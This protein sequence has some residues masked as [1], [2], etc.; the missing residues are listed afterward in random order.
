M[1][2]PGNVILARVFLAFFGLISAWI[3]GLEVHRLMTWPTV[4]ATIIGTGVQGVHGGRNGIGYR[5][6]AAYSYAVNGSLDTAT[7]VTV[8]PISS[9]EKWAQSVSHQFTQGAT[10]TA[11]INPSNPRDGYLV[12]RFSLVPVWLFLP[13]LFFWLLFN[14][15]PG[16]Q[17]IAIVVDG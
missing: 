12:H 11:Y 1:R 15:S 5:P 6:V 17:R 8:I 2:T 7:G 16:R 14:R 4:Q 3:A 9:S 10:V 13:G